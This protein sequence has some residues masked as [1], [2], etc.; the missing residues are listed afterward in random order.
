MTTQAWLALL[1]T[2]GVFLGLQ[3]RKGVPTDL[4]FVLGV[5]AVT[6]LRIITPAEA[7]GG[8]ANPGV[9]LVGAMFVIAA[10]MRTTGV[11]DWIGQQLLGR[12]TSEPSA[13]RRLAAA[14]LPSS[15]FMPNSP[16]VAM[17][18]PVVVDW[19]RKR[20]VS[21]SRLLIPVSYLSILGGVCTLVGTSTTLVVQAAL[22]TEYESR[23]WLEMP[24]FRSQLREMSLFEIGQ[25]GLPC[26]LI[27][28]A[29]LIVFA[30][31]LL[32]NRQ[33]IVSQVGEH[34]REYLVE[35]LV[36]PECRLIGKTV[37]DAGL[38]GLEGLFLIEINRGGEIL[39]PVTPKDVIQSGDRLV[40]T[41]VVATIV[42][43]E[44]I[45]GF[46]PAADLAYEV[47]PDERHQRHLTEAVLSRTSPLI[48]RTVRAANFRQRYGAAVVAVHRNGQRV[49]N[50]IGSIVLEAGDT[51]LLQTR[52]DFAEA[53]RDNADFYLVSA[54][55][56][57]TPLRHER[58]LLSAILMLVLVAWL[59]ATDFPPIKDWPGFNSPAVAAVVM[60]ALFV[61]T[62]CLPIAA[63]RSALDL[64]VLITIAAAIGLGQAL[65]ASGAAAAIAAQLVQLAGQDQ[66]YLLLIMLF[67]LTVA[68]GELMSNNAV[69]AM[70][71][72]LAVQLAYAGGHSPRP[73]ILGVALAASFSF[74]TPVGYQTNLMVMGPGGYRPMDF[75]RAGWP[76]SAAVSVTALIIIPYVW[77]FAG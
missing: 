45:P 73:F 14:L 20:N 8:F 49:T 36:R 33:D 59:S 6:L 16:V 60:A 29:V 77:P 64:Q 2:L 72:P 63:A 54:V 15:A 56:G 74:L 26:A 76:V 5:S 43:L 3:V 32:P 42:D 47:R 24:A 39:A 37:E 71:F 28:A 23:R 61:V 35:M 1:V 46:V 19:C 30:R 57:S 70:M 21:P 52:T 9:I 65:S 51:L 55:E 11:L 31:K 4:V 67:A 13:L 40:F 50:K 75:V 69:A 44:R 12:V 27:G 66:P 34:R 7:L 17:M 62:G 53:F 18:V 48:G 22:R 58:A 41:G 38:R 10:G 25:A 68:F